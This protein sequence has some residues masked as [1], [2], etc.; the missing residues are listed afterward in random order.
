MLLKC[1]CSRPFI[2]SELCLWWFLACVFVSQSSCSWVLDRGNIVI[3]TGPS[4]PPSLVPLGVSHHQRVQLGEPEL[5]AQDSEFWPAVKSIFLIDEK[6]DCRAGDVWRKQSSVL[7][8]LSLGMWASCKPWL[9]PGDLKSWKGTQNSFALVC[10]DLTFCLFSL[11]SSVWK[12][13]RKEIKKNPFC[14][15]EG[16]KL[17]FK[18]KTFERVV[19]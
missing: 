18:K 5:S 15:V 1:C 13:W 12:L 3:V 4:L 8:S 17:K 16:V 11:C 14:W 19:S 10:V 7:P 9:W 6:R 2:S